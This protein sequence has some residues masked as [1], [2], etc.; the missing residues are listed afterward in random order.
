MDI[1]NI[2]TFK[3]LS[4]I[5]KK[6]FT[7]RY[8]SIFLSDIH[9][10]SNSPNHNI[11]LNEFQKMESD[12]LFLIGDI[13]S[14]NAIDNHKNIERFREILESKSWNIIYIN[15][16]H[17]DEREERFSKSR[18][19]ISYHKDIVGVAN[20]IYTSN[21]RIYL[22]HGHSFHKKDVWNI[23]LRRS[24]LIYKK[25]RKVNKLVQSSKNRDSSSFYF[26]YIKPLAQKVLSS[27]FEKY[28]V[29]IAK[30]QDCSI[31][32]CGHLHLPKDIVVDS[33]RYLNCGDWIKS[34]SYIVEDNNGTLSLVN[35]K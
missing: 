17:E 1:Y 21:N 35:L 5:K 12:N 10:G 4:Y 18:I 11:F 32:I 33:V 24:I 8:K 14:I 20:Y 15:G 25:I 6:D 26:K 3:I 29:S 34:N 13:F 19:S 30:E 31:V 16:N 27:S 28:M 9:L 23:A 22:E 7:M 2:Y